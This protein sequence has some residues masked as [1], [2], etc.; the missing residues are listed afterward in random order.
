M[1]CETS[2]INSTLGANGCSGASA[3]DRALQLVNQ[4]FTTAEQ[5]GLKALVD[6]ARPLKVAA[7][8]AASSAV[9]LAST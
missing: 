9:L 3:T 4:A 5:L 1:P 6:K 8:T 2:P 7:E